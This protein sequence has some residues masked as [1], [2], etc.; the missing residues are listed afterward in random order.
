MKNKLICPICKNGF[1]QKHSR[2]QY[3]S[4]ECSLIF[5]QE[6]E[7]KYAKIYYNR[8]KAEL[9]KKAKIYREEHK[10]E[11]NKYR[12]TRKNET[13][14]YIKNKRKTDINF[15]LKCNLRKRIWQALKGNP[16]SN[17]LK[18][19]IGC[20]IEHLR[21]HLQKQFKDSMFW[22]NYGKW[23][24]DHIKPCASFDLSKASEQKKC[25][26]Y[27]NLQP[28]WAIENFIKNDNYD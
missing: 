27:K 23:H 14:L 1:I 10:V 7:I 11:I 3:C 21:E 19:L 8:N 17:H 6:Y 5:R 26:N 24:I 12:R 9:L 18:K 28:L 13:S 20:S 25:F 2:Q 22:S 16:K 15:A 4:K